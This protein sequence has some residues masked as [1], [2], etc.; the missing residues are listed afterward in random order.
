MRD[1]FIWL[2][3]QV[4]A[5]F[6]VAKDK[7]TPEGKPEENVDATLVPAEHEPGGAPAVLPSTNTITGPLSALQ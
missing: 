5:L 4:E 2:D 3:A 6:Y 7:S 1:V